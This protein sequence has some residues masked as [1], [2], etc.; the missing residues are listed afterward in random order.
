MNQQQGKTEPQPKRRIKK[1]EEEE[2]KRPWLSG[3]ELMQGWDLGR[4]GV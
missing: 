4:G 3:V 2:K 1:K